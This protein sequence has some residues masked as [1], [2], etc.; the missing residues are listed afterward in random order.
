[1][2]KP[3]TFFF[4]RS[5]KQITAIKIAAALWNHNNIIGFLTKYFPPT[6]RE[7][8]IM[9]Q[10]VKENLNN[11]Q[12]PEYLKENILCFVSPMGRRLSEWYVKHERSFPGVRLLYEFVWTSDCVIDERETAKILVADEGL[13]IVTRYK[14][15][16]TYCIES[17]IPILWKKMPLN[18]RYWNYNPDEAFVALWTYEMGG[19][20]NEDQIKEIIKEFSYECSFYSFAFQFA[21]HDLNKSAVE[22]YLQKLSTVEKNSLLAVATQIVAKVY[23]KCILP[24]TDINVLCLLLSQM[25]L[26]QQM[27]IFKLC[28]ADILCCYF[29]WPT[30]IELDICL[31][32]LYQMWDFLS[33]KNYI[34]LLETIAPRLDENPHGLYYS[35]LFSEVWHMSTPQ[36]KEDTVSESDFLFIS[37]FSMGDL[38]YVSLIFTSASV[39]AKK[40]LIFSA[41][42][43]HILK[44]LLSLSEWFK[45]HFFLNECLANA[46]EVLALQE[47]MKEQF[48]NIFYVP[49]LYG[50]T[51]NTRNRQKWFKFFQILQNFA[52]KFNGNEMVQE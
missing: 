32:K 35:K 6:F 48:E 26:D 25:N 43:I 34:Y 5:L 39:A 44:N 46:D 10:N 37:L 12:L 45:I 21:A 51:R 33:N 11:L 41:Q 20:V 8:Q 42:G 22:F 36:Y 27:N 16:C 31:E 19:D 30:V 29:H 14:L 47:T 38:K 49:F 7:F 50:E 1:M 2:D 40:K 9:N 17:A 4:V 28:A 18:D 15:A 24:C 23:S 13:N 52:L 3:I